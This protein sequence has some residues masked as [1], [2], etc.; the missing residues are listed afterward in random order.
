MKQFN[1]KLGIALVIV[2]IL[3]VT[4]NY[5]SILVNPA[6]AVSSFVGF[7]AGIVTMIQVYHYQP[8]QDHEPGWF[9]LAFSTVYGIVLVAVF[10]ATG[11][12]LMKEH[13]ALSLMN[14]LSP[15]L[16]PIIGVFFGD[17]GRILIKGEAP[18]M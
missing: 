6:L 15:A 13:L 8:S 3:S 17:V 1:K 16:L 2:S 7:L 14:G 12:N 10:Y 4:A 5:F 18:A 9:W 11:T